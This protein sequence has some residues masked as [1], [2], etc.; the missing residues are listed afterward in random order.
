MC[1]GKEALLK[2]LL[3]LDKENIF[4]TRAYAWLW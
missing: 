1:N 3:A 4:L 2:S